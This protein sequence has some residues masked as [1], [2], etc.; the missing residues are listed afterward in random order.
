MHHGCVHILGDEDRHVACR[1][2][3]AHEDVV[4][5]LRAGHENGMD[6]MAGFVHLVDDLV[7]LKR[8]E[9]HCGVVKERKTIDGLVTAQANDRAC[10]TWVGNGRAIAEEIAIEEE[11]TAKVRDSGRLLLLLHIL[12]MLVE[13]IVDVGIVRF[14]DTECLLES[15]MCFE[16]VLQELSCCAL[17]SLG[18]PVSWNQDVTI[19][20]PDP[21]D[22]DRFR[23]HGNVTGRCT[24]DCCKTAERLMLVGGGE[25]G[26]Q[27]VTAQLDFGS[28]GT[29][30]AGISIDDTTANSDAGYQT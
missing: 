27:F 8:D 21:L 10:H 13:I 14:R 9:L 5:A 16:D 30:P 2:H 7:G 4:L 29:N 20:A 22:E 19:G 17:T 28:D 1:S 11:V 24:G 12:K 15:R 26:A 18:H 6:L 23:R 25:L 3:E